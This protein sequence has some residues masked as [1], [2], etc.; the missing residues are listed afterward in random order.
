MLGVKRCRQSV[1]S[2]SSSSSA[3]RMVRYV[4]VGVGAIGG[5]VAVK[6]WATGCDVTG[7]APG[8]PVLVH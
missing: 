7:Y 1:L 4:V 2:G 6:L 8:G 5:T 3:E